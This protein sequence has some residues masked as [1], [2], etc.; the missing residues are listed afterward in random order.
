MIFATALRKELL[1]QWRTYRMLIIAVVLL[2]FGMMSPLLAKLAPE[3]IRMVPG[4]EDLVSLIP[5]PSVADAIAQYVKNISQ[6]AF[7]LA[8]LAAMAIVAQEKEKGTAV[9]MLVKPL[10]RG[11]FLLAK[12]V[13]LALVFLLS[14]ALAGA[15]AYYY[16]V[17]LFEAPDPVAWIWMNVLLWVYVMVYVAVT[18]LGSTL[19]KSQAGAAALGFAALVVF[20]IVGALPNLGQHLPNQ[21]VSW[22]GSAFSAPAQ[23]AWS[24]LAVSLA[25]IGGCLLLSWA[26]FERQEL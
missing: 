15:A 12:F 4:G 1:E 10:G 20:T 8:L 3:L 6:F 16:T 14:L 5:Q 25:I 21:L 23:T 22:A 7:L 18:L 24:A 17:V 9:L 13:A 11:H 2:A 26:A 19:W